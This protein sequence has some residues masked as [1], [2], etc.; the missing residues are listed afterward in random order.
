[1]ERVHDTL[2]LDEVD[3]NFGEEYGV[4]KHGNHLNTDLNIAHLTNFQCTILTAVIQKYWCVFS[5]KVMTYPIKNYE[6]EIDTGNA[7]HIAF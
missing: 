2:P 6:F 4:A 1:M 3:P 7:H 5:K